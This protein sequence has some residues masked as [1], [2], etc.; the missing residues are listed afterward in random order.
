MENIEFYMLI[1]IAIL[2]VIDGPSIA[3]QI[4]KLLSVLIGGP[5]NGQNKTIIQNIKAEN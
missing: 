2:Q 4:G 1:A 5:R 3:Q